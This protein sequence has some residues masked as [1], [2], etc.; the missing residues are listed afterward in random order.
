MSHQVAGSPGRSQGSAQATSVP[1]HLTIPNG[2]TWCQN[3]PRKMT[4]HTPSSGCLLLTQQISTAKCPA[5]SPPNPAAS[6]HP[7]LSVHRNSMCRC[8]P[9][10]QVVLVTQTQ[11]SM[12]STQTMAPELLATISSMAC[13]KPA[14]WVVYGQGGGHLHKLNVLD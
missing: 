3:F 6:P 11:I 1:S 9:V 5:P 2:Q 8:N 14:S 12:K 7:G 10:R 4:L 13:T